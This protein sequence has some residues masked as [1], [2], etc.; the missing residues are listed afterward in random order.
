MDINKTKLHYKGLGIGMDCV[1]P[2]VGRVAD[3]CHRHGTKT[4]EGTKGT[5]CLLLLHTAF[6]KA[7]PKDECLLCG[8]ASQADVCAP[9]MRIQ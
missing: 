3:W 7:L 9:G 4:G 6:L 8:S 1:I 5:R 2:G